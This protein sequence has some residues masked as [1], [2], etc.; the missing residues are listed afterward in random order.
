MGFTLAEVPDLFELRAKGSC[1]ATRSLA[2]SKLQAIEERIQELRS[3]HRELTR[4][5]TKCD[6]NAQDSACPVMERL[7]ASIP[8]PHRR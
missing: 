2:L 3:L 6:T 5:V 1:Q 8:A 4:L 7:S